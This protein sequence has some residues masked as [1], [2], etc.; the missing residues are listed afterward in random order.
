MEGLYPRRQ[1]PHRIASQFDLSR[2]GRGKKAS[3]TRIKPLVAGLTDRERGQRI[4]NRVISAC[5]SCNRRRR[6]YK[7]ID[8]HGAA[9]FVV[10]QD[11]RF[12]IGRGAGAGHAF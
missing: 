6:A 7:L 3:S 11:R 5:S 9:E 8:F 1:P 2:K 12:V 10:L 4:E